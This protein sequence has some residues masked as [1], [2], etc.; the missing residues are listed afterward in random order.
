MLLFVEILNIVLPVFVVIALGYLLR[1]LQL[2]DATFLFQTNRLIYYIALPILLF[3]K[4]GTADFS[5]TSTPP[6][7]SARRR[8]LPSPSCF[9]TATPPSPLSARRSRHLQPGG[10]RGNLAYVGLAIVINAYGEA[11]FTRAGILMGFLSP[12]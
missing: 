6:S 10:F 4:I 11:G 7:S 9:R 2:I 3:Y 5:P 1:R 8:P 12:Y